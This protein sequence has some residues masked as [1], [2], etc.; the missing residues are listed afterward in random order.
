MNGR[1]L[2][3]NHDGVYVIRFEGDVR[4]TICGS[5]DHYL[6]VML[7]DSDFVSAV[8]D[9]SG[10]VA[11]DSTSLG[12]LAKLS[13]AMQARFDRVPTLVCNSPDIMRILQN[14][15]FADVFTIVDEHFAAQQNLAEL[16]VSSD[17]REDEIRERVIEAHRVLMSLNE[18]NRATFKDLVSALE[19]EGLAR[20]S[21]ADDD[22]VSAG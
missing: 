20:Q 10:A 4:V 12:V 18:Q 13:I 21:P 3:G 14:M 1:I 11:I 5:F 7:G 15:G 6:D 8:V 19:E 2:V 22:T 9:L 17:L 16:P